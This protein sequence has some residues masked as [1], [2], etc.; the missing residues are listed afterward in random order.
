MPPPLLLLG[1]RKV[2]TITT[3]MFARIHVTGKTKLSLGNNF[4]FPTF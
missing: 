4:F 1:I 2:K 3:E